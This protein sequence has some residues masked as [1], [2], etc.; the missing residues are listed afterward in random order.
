MSLFGIQCD[1][2]GRFINPCAPG[3][4]WSQTRTWMT[5]S[6]TVYR[7]AGCTHKHGARQTNIEAPGY[8][9]INPTAEITARAQGGGDVNKQHAGS[10]AV[11]SDCGNFRYALRR[12]WGGGCRSVLFVMLN[13][14]TADASVDDPTIRKCVAFARLWGYDGIRVVNLFAKR[15][16]DPD[17]LIGAEE[18]SIG[19]ACD[20]WI[21]SEA[22]LADLVVCAWG[23]HKS[24]QWRAGTV[25]RLIERANPGVA[26]M[27]L[28]TNGNGSPKHPL[29]LSGKTTLTQY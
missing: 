10:N 19:D 5:L 29:Y 15:S 8:A 2:C 16:T 12:T 4:S 7:C 24:A 25:R 9:G 26:I 14:S 28:G 22:V 23:A 27:C 20:Q 21:E 6:D 11:L 1:R 17:A 13:P 18:I 3:V